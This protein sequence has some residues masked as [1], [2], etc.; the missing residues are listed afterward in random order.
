MK[1]QG[2]MEKP[3]AMFL[4]DKMYYRFL[5]RVKIWGRDLVISEENHIFAV[6]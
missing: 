1:L 2:K 6:V 4:I 5:S 3:I